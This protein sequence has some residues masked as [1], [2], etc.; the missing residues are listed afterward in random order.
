MSKYKPT[1]VANMAQKPSDFSDNIVGTDKETMAAILSTT[2][3]TP[4]FDTI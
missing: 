2:V 1:I 4:C 3:A